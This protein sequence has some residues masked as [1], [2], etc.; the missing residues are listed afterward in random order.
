[1]IT[2]TLSEEQRKFLLYIQ[3]HHASVGWF[4]RIQFILRDDEYNPTEMD[5]VLLDWRRLVSD[6]RY[7]TLYGTPKKYLK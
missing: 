2:N 7:Q 1:M 4:Q 5:S 6:T 3:E